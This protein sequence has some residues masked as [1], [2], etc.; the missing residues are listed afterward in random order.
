M[1]PTV[2]LEREGCRHALSAGTFIKGENDESTSILCAQL[3]LAWAS[4][5]L[6][7]TSKLSVGETMI[8]MEFAPSKTSQANETRHHRSTFATDDRLVGLHSRIPTPNQVEVVQKKNCR[9]DDS[10]N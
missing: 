4:D 9:G 10:A 2:H 5:N 7:L 1:P 3:A 8:Q 6:L